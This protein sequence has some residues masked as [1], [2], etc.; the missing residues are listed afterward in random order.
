MV[1]KRPLSGKNF[2]QRKVRDIFI[3]KKS[4]LEGEVLERDEK[5][6]SM[7]RS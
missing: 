3:R 5:N 7:K 4:K 6:I 1:I 2:R